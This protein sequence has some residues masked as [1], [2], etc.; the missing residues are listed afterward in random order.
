M[1]Q[2]VLFG[3]KWFLISHS[4]HNIPII[5]H[6]TNAS[7]HF[8]WGTEHEAHLAE[9]H[10]QCVWTQNTASYLGRQLVVPVSVDMV[11]LTTAQ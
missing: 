5:V 1:L 2:H 4:Y 8:L 11:C 7:A 6:S 3:L 10:G 9:L